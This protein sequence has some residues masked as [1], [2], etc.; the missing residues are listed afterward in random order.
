MF[1]NCLWNLHLWKSI[2]RF[3]DEASLPHSGVHS[4][5]I[6][7]HLYYFHGKLYIL[8]QQKEW[9]KVKK[10]EKKEWQ[11]TAHYVQCCT[12]SLYIILVFHDTCRIAY[13]SFKSVSCIRHSSM[14]AD[15]HWGFWLTIFYARF[16]LWTFQTFW[17]VEIFV[18]YV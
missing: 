6:L 14:C 13:T 15:V 17:L 2:S 7:F 1:S 10:K 8:K 3:T 9:E 5:V 12:L 16:Q 4:A 11:E 18:V